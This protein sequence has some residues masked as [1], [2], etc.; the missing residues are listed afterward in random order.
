MSALPKEA[1]ARKPASK[2]NARRKVRSEAARVPVYRAVDGISASI[3]EAGFAGERISD[4][5]LRTGWAK[6]SDGPTK[7]SFTL[8]TIL[9][10]NGNP[11]MQREW[12]RRRIKEDDD[13]VFWYRPMGGGSGR[14]KSVIGIV[15][16]IGLAVFAPWAG[17]AVFGAG[18]VGAAFFTAAIGTGGVLSSTK[19]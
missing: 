4:F 10:I 14:G 3:T 19:R 16:A 5:L 8:P 2:R 9:V 12:K 1:T 7:W 18:T 13:I 6:P 17:A 15:A 11:V